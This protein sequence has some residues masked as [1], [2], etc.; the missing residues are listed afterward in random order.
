[1]PNRVNVVVASDDNYI[2]HLAVTLYSV[3]ANRGVNQQ[4]YLYVL[5]AGITDHSRRRLA[6]M[7]NEP[8][9]HLEVISPTLGDVGNIPLKRYGHAALLRISIAD[10][11]PQ[12]ITR[13]IYLDCDIVVLSDLQYLMEVDLRNH[14]IG[15]VENLGSRATARLGIEPGHYFN[16]GVLVM[17]LDK[18]REQHIGDKVMAYMQENSDMLHFP[19]QDGLNAVLH[20][21]WLR[22]PLKWNQQPATYSMLGKQAAGTQR[23]QEFFEAASA[24]Y[25]VHFLARNKPWH[26]MTFHPLK[27]IY[28][29]Y[30]RKTPWQGYRYPD[31]NPTNITKKWLMLEK[32]FKQWQRRRLGVKFPA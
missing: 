21:D 4:L 11:L 30:L 1:M 18:W 22:L 29:H 31:R 15:A 24:P 19:D 7:F 16:S 25:I 23:R 13:A 26:Y 20:E 9:V 5:D 14:P 17:D 2:Q 6:A 10:L 3:V 28:W 27:G 12:E 32:L 8:G